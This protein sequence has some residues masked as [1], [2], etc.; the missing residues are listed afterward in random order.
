MTTVLVNCTK[1]NTDF[2]KNKSQV[3]R[4]NNHFCTNKCSRDYNIILQK[5][6]LKK[7]KDD[8]YN[9]PKKCINC[10]NI[11]E[12]ENK[13]KKNYCSRKCS[14][15]YS[16]KNGGH[17]KWSDLDKKKLSELAYKNNK[18]C[19]WN[20]KEKIK[21]ECETCKSKFEI[22]PSL[23]KRNCCS[24]KC[25]NEWIKNTGYLKNKGLGGYRKNSGTSKRGWYKG[26]FCG[27]SWELA[28]V[29]Y[30]LEHN[31]KFD[32]NDEGFN[33]V[34]NGIN[35]K[36]YPDFKIG[37]V[38]IE[39]KGYHSK[40]FDAKQSQFP[41]KL[42]VLHKSDLKEILSYVIKKYGKK[43]INLYDK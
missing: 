2:L 24:R 31:V 26:Y 19:G 17:K 29:I 23:E 28:W 5:T 7:R 13:N 3:K 40:Q 37:D 12:F 22:I 4:T 41:F 36:Y 20:R 8:Y 43:F 18:F 15:I 11:I 27:S 1:C 6:L 38:Y 16:Q 25:K 42:K 10:Q 33:Y 34:Y 32:R 21:K 39:I 14:A 35:K 30:N 9:N